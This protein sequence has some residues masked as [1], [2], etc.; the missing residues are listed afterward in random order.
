MTMPRRAAVAGWVIM[1][2]AVALFGYN[3]LIMVRHWDELAPVNLDR[4]APDLTLAT[5]EGASVRLGSLRGRVVLLDFW[6]SWCG[7][8]M[9]AMPALAKLGRELGPRGLTILSINTDESRGAAVELQRSHGGALTV[10]LDDGAAAARYGVQTLPHL[11][12]IGRDGRV[13]AI[14]VG[15]VPEAE[16]RDRLLRVIAPST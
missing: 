7:P 15:A 14:L 12:I 16:L 8:C 5:V 6:A 10:T 1:A 13:R 11:V 2:V 3:L 9:R 4:P